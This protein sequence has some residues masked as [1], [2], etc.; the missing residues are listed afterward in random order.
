MLLWRGLSF[1]LGHCPRFRKNLPN[2]KG[3]DIGLEKNQ[4]LT[5]TY[6]IRFSWVLSQIN[7]AS[8]LICFR[9][10]AIIQ[11]FEKFCSSKNINVHYQM[12][13]F[14]HSTDEAF[15]HVPKMA[16]QDPTNTHTQIPKMQRSTK[17]LVRVRKPFF[18][19]VRDGNGRLRETFRCKPCSLH[20]YFF[21]YSTESEIFP[22]GWKQVKTKMKRTRLKYNSVFMCSLLSQR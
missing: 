19:P 18:T 6:Y 13:P 15:N 12:G 1:P 2:I 14:I 8:Q 16:P 3:T 4:Y 5:I 22:N 20:F 7:R 10:P 11:L 9:K 21:M 17:R